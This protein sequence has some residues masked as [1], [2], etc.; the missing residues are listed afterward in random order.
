MAKMPIGDNLGCGHARIH[1]GSGTII[2]TVFVVNATLIIR[3]AN[4]CEG[5]FNY[6][7]L[8]D[9]SNEVSKAG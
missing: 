3:V 5:Q 6:A 2:L 1:N 7:G 9:V 8:K 4:N